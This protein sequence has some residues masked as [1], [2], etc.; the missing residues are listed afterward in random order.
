[1]TNRTGERSRATRGRRNNC[2]AQPGELPFPCGWGGWRPG[3][4][5]KRSPRSGVRHVARPKLSQHVPVHLTWRIGEGLPI[6]RRPEC[7]AVLR[8]AFEAGKQCFGFRLV[9]F[10]VQANHLHLIAEADDRRALSRGMR[11]LGV[12]IAKRLNVESSIWNAPASSV[13]A[14]LS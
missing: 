3:S 8:E 1:M 12:R 14:C 2:A 5:R 10:S 11:A 7:M 6:L 9:Q 13:E 4:G